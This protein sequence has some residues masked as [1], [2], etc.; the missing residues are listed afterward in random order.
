MHRGSEVPV[1]RIH[2]KAY[3]RWGADAEGQATCQWGW[4]GVH[5]L[6]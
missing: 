6:A 1:C 4:A 5:A 3:T 2:E